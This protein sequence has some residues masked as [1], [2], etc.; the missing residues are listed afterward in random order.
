MICP[1]VEQITCHPVSLPG[2]FFPVR[3]EEI[4][5]REG[6]QRNHFLVALGFLPQFAGRRTAVLRG[7]E[8][9]S[10]V[11]RHA[12]PVVIHRFH[13]L[14]RENRRGLALVQVSFGAL[15]DPS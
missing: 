14:V 3:H 8:K 11:F 13:E 1:T 9:L 7:T 2:T 4:T 6:Q 5:P 12:A 10:R 15:D